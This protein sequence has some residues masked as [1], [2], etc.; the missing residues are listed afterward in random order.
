M[1]RVKRKESLFVE[2]VVEGLWE[3]LEDKSFEKISVSELVERAGIDRVTF[4]R[5]FSNKEE[6]LKRSFNMELQAWLSERQIDLSDWTDGQLLSALRQFF[7]FWY[8][9]QDNIRLLICLT[10]ILIALVAK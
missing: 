8:E 10:G 5:N 7:D 9:Q 1:E 4:Y 6:V 2:S 3:L